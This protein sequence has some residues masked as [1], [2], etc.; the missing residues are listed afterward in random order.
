M[1]K[2]FT[3]KEFLRLLM[4]VADD[5][6]RAYHCTLET[7]SLIRHILATDYPYQQDDIEYIADTINYHLRC[8]Q[9]KGEKR[10]FPISKYLDQICKD[11]FY[12]SE[13]LNSGGI[14]T[15]LSP[16]NIRRPG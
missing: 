1:I 9:Y 4:R 3:Y 8:L 7:I 11:E 15:V 14:S 12:I 16:Y 5:N 6:G 2:Q 13:Y 10:R